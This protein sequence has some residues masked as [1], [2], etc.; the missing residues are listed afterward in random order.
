[1]RAQSSNPQVACQFSAQCGY[2]NDKKFR[3]SLFKGLRGP[4]FAS[5]P[6]SFPSENCEGTVC[7][8]TVWFPK[9]TVAP[10]EPTGTHD[11]PVM[12]FAVFRSGER[13]KPIKG[14][15]LGKAL[16]DAGLF[17]NC[18]GSTA[19]YAVTGTTWGGTA[20]LRRS[21]EFCQGKTLSLAYAK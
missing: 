8:Q 17:Q 11:L 1:M 2:D 5:E 15:S 3:S 20:C 9:G 14:V 12:F 6:N 13:E 16:L 7:L 4:R 10:W 19:G 21:E 18:E